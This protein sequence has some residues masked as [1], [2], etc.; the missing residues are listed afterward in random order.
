MV[1]SQRVSLIRALGALAMLALSSVCSEPLTLFRE[2]PSAAPCSGLFDTSG[3]VG[4]MSKRDEALNVGAPRLFETAASF[5]SAL[6][7]G[8]FRGSWIITD[9]VWC[10]MTT[11]QML[12][13][14]AL[15]TSLIIIEN[16]APLGS[17]S[18]TSFDATWNKFGRG[19]KQLGLEFPVARLN[20][21]DARAVHD[22]LSSP[23]PQKM[24]FDFYMGR[25][26][27]SVNSTY[28]LDILRCSPLGG[29]SVWGTVKAAP[30]TGAE[31]VVLLAANMDSTAFF[32]DLAPGFHAAGGDI[33]LALSAMHALALAPS[34][35]TRIVM[36]IFQGE[37]FGRIGSRRF[38]EDVLLGT[39]TNLT[40]SSNDS[41]A[42]PPSFSLEHLKFQ[43]QLGRFKRIIALNNVL[44]S[45]LA[46]N[47]TYVHGIETPL[48]VSNDIA[49]RL[50][51][52]LSKL[53][54]ESPFPEI[55][56]AENV[57]PSALNSFIERA[58]WRGSNSTGGIVF[59]G[60]QADVSEAN[61]H[62]ETEWDRMN[63]SQLEV[64]TDRASLL[65]TALARTLFFFASNG[66]E[67]SLVT[68]RSL[69]RDL[70][71]CFGADFATDCPMAL[72][73]LNLTTR[74]LATFVANS[75]PAAATPY[76]VSL[77]QPLTSFTGVYSPFAVSSGRVK[78][79]EAFIRNVMANLSIGGAIPLPRVSSGAFFPC[80]SDVTCRDLW[81]DV[82]SCPG[83]VASNASAA[84]VAGRCICSS[85]FFHDAWSPSLIITGDKFTIVNGTL[86]DNRIWTE[87]FWSMPELKSFAVVTTV[88][89]AVSLTVGI[90]LTIG[91][92]AL[93]QYT[94]KRGEVLGK[95]K[96]A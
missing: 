2:F 43:G 81:K 85:V 14:K 19:L 64:Y 29:L 70:L 54:W 42:N 66:T 50:T 58:A 9:E 20:G 82:A 31:D 35:S 6:S 92:I 32:H 41:C 93:I 44:R 91:A 3:F 37:S 67:S 21:D 13:L 38:L 95:L 30:L 59:S 94:K 79:R 8:S 83:P 80:N 33:V 73:S 61:P 89:T 96:L 18:S 40:K 11:Q 45:D 25:S 57:P 76:L 10:T 4:C 56:P 65:S 34:T 55:K 17:C 62:F 53:G 15:A 16:S 22:V 75:A 84:C 69:V 52:E 36:A 26:D 71:R 63:V 39:C 7:A 51:F 27:G 24:R 74:Q 72:T 60:F 90:L 23:G 47:R 12:D 48:N 86:L 46:V 68:D 1:P 78:I 77:E 5:Q 49:D 28:C 87:P 88:D